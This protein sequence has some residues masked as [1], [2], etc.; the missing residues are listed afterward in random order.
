MEKVKGELLYEGKAK[1]MFAVQ[2]RPE[3]VW[4]Q[5]K[6]SLTAFNAQKKGNFD[7]K[8]AINAQITSL[9]YQRLKSEGVPTHWLAD[10][11][12]TEMICEKVKIIP[13]EV[14]TRNRLAGSTAKK[15][16][17]DEGTKIPQPLVEFYFKDDALSDPFVSDDQALMIGAVEKREDLEVL[18]RAALTINK[19][20]RAE[21]EKAGLELID[22]KLEFGRNPKGQIV[23]ADEI[24]PD[25]CRLW[26]LKTGDKYDKDRFRRDLGGVEEAYQEVLRRLKKALGGRS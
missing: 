22:F 15:L 21:F 25:T 26:D 18:K 1:K 11:N 14:V 24:S 2:G 4:V 13:L 12:P 10:V 5:Y 23:L 7:G 19:I 20:L 8:G 3:E 9:L 17:K 6:D 16:G